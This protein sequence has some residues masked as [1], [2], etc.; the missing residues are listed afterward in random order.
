MSIDKPLK[1]Q[2]N[3]NCEWIF[4]EPSFKKRLNNFFLEFIREI[5]SCYVVTYAQDHT[6]KFTLF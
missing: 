6:H 5:F 1:V 3:K 2:E 4:R